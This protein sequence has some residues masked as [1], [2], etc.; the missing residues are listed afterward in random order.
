MLLQF[1]MTDLY[2]KFEFRFSSL[3]MYTVFGM[4]MKTK[5]LNVHLNLQEARGGLVQVETCSV[6]LSK[7]TE[8]NR[9]NQQRKS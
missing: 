2:T 1:T 9:E 7:R 3:K 4:K 5:K 8:A 6:F